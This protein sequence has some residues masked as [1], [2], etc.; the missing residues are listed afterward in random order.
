MTFRSTRSQESADAYNE[1][2]FETSPRMARLDRLEQ[3]FAAETMALLGERAAV[4]DIPCGSG[5][6]V[7]I[8]GSAERYLMFDY[9]PTMLRAALAQHG[10]NISPNQMAVA[11]VTDIP[12]PTDAVDL[13]F[14]MRLFHHID[15]PEFRVAALAEMARVSR[16]YVAFSFYCTASWRYM[17]RRIRGRKPSGHAISSRQMTA[18]AESVGLKFIR[19]FPR[20]ELIEQQRLMLFECPSNA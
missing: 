13:A 6:F 11:D 9:A 4:L 5:R 19:R 16:R 7:D 2:R 20:R 12:L 18:E 10:D 17:R 15:A 1:T 3:E 8:F 14:C